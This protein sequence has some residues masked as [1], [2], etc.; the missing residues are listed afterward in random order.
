MW[1]LIAC[2]SSVGRVFYKTKSR[3]ALTIHGDSILL[4]GPCGSGKTVLFYAVCFCSMK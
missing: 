3:R 4:L 1:I 2:M